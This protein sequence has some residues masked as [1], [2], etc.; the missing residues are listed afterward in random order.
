VNLIGGHTDYN[1][2]FVMPVAI[3]R[4]MLLS[5]RICQRQNH[6]H[7]ETFDDEHWFFILKNGHHPKYCNCN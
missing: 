5:A 7:E 1:D 2:G 3:N 6:T 4:E